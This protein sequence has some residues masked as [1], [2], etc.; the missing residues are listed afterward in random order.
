MYYQTKVHPSERA[1]FEMR[2][3]TVHPPTHM[4]GSL[5]DRALAAPVNVAIEQMYRKEGSEE[6]DGACSVK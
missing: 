5:I 6:T 2:E 3:S 4:P 1:H